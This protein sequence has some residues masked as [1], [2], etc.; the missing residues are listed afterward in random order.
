MS[1]FAWRVCHKINHYIMPG[2]SSSPRFSHLFVVLSARLIVP[3]YTHTPLHK[4]AW[5]LDMVGS[6]KL[7][8]VRKC[9]KGVCVRSLGVCSWMVVCVCVCGW[10]VWLLAQKPAGWVESAMC[11]FGLWTFH[12]EEIHLLPVAQGKAGERSKEGKRQER[13]VN[14]S[15]VCAQNLPN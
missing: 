11:G 7:D 5:L 15:S 8:W 10:S 4:A 9:E 1:H 13:K 12:S 3:T 6:G 14:L 2:F